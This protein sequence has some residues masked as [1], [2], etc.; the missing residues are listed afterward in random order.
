MFV[1]LLQ[2][3]HTVNAAKKNYCHFCPWVCFSTS[4]VTAFLQLDCW[5]YL[6]FHHESMSHP[7]PF[8][9]TVKRTV[10]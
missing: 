3:I 5:K 7:Q 6:Q 10:K 8:S 9:G 4:I 1:L 2:C